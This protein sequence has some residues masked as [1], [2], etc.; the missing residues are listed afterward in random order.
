M[1]DI[2]DFRESPVNNEVWGRI[3]LEV[4]LGLWVSFVKSQHLF[5]HTANAIIVMAAMVLTHCVRIYDRSL[6]ITCDIYFRLELHPYIVHIGIW[7]AAVY[8]ISARKHWLLQYLSTVATGCA[9]LIHGSFELFSAACHYLALTPFYHNNEKVSILAYLAF[10]AI[11]IAA[12]ANIQYR[13][14]AEKVQ[15][16]QNSCERMSI[17]DFERTGYHSTISEMMKLRNACVANPDAFR[18]IK[19]KERFEAFLKNPRDMGIQL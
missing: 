5:K 7:I 14:W 11:I 15:A 3:L 12:S 19:H 2:L 9:L 17:A 16:S 1:M 18:N 13:Y 6:N 10:A 8:A 4:F